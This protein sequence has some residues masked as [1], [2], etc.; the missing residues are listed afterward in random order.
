[1][2]PGAILVRFGAMFVAAVRLRAP[3]CHTGSAAAVAAASWNEF[4]HSSA[5]AMFLARAGTADGD[6]VFELV[7]PAF[8]DLLGLKPAAL[9]GRN[10]AACLPVDVANI[11][12]SRWRES[13]RSFAPVQY[14]MVTNCAAGRR[15]WETIVTPIRGA[16]GAA[17]GIVGTARDI[18]E[19]VRQE[20]T[21]RQAQRMEAAA[22]LSTGVAHDFNN[23]LQAVSGGLE[24]VHEQ[25]DLDA[26]SREGLMVAV[27]AARRASMLT[28]RL[29]AYSG[30]QPLAPKPLQPDLMIADVAARL[31]RTCGERFRIRTIVR[32][33]VWS[34]RADP[35]QL[36]DC[37]FH[38]AMNACD[39][40]PDGGLL[41]LRVDTIGAEASAEAGL[42]PGEFVRFVVEDRGV[43]MSAEVLERA[44][45]PFF[46]TKEVGEGAGLGLS[47]VLG[48]A[49]QSGGDLHIESRQGQGTKVNLWLP[50]A[51]DAS[52]QPV[53][54]RDRE[55][56]GRGRVL[57]VDDEDVVRRTLTLFLKRAGFS[58]VAFSGGAAALDW[59]RTGEACDLLVTD[60][61]MPGLTGCDLINEIALLRPNLPVL[62]VTGYDKI[63]LL[64]QVRARVAILRK[65]FDR[66]ALECQVQALLGQK[67]QVEHQRTRR[68]DAQP[69]P[70]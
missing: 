1:M 14:T 60:Q 10:A 4:A 7:N 66:A 15:D 63:S 57:V 69:L 54:E 21:L 36:Q 3:F 17:C 16:G 30:K 2:S 65:P 28:H 11:A 45:E 40:M 51:A 43:G 5:D 27:Q 23:L 47:M 52:T 24:L 59:L 32:K 44:L 67:P 37:L 46:T 35:V 50:R 6:F 8:A 38:L 19:R 49:R 68:T 29:L 13:V 70:A 33:P 22:Q 61:S 56:Y 9:R 31:E 55:G 58:P 12:L 62:L 39:A 48:F 26:D 20:V 53:V 25:P 42:P 41:R 34:V 18:T 64:E